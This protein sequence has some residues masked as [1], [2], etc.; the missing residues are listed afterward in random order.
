MAVQRHV[1]DITDD[2]SKAL[3]KS[4]GQLVYY[5]VPLGES[6]YIRDSA[7]LLLSIRGVDE[8][9]RVTDD[10]ASSIHGLSAG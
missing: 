4:C 9:F 6:T 1:R 8:N 5:S 3:E 7:Q 2:L 10:L